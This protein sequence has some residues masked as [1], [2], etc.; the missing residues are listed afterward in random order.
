[1]IMIYIEIDIDAIDTETDTV[2]DFELNQGP[3]FA[4]PGTL[5]LNDRFYFIFFIFLFFYF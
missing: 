5:L 4:K 1:M 3:V 2:I